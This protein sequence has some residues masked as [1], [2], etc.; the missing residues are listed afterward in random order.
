MSPGSPLWRWLERVLFLVGFLVLIHP[1]ASNTYYI[2]IDGP[3]HCYTST[4]L[5]TQWS[6]QDRLWEISPHPVPNWTGHTHLDAS[7]QL[8]PSVGDAWSLAPYS[9]SPS[10]ENV[11]Q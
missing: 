9:K 10:P 1:V 8:G 11:H 4:L 2:T 7:Y 3:S 5:A 6:N